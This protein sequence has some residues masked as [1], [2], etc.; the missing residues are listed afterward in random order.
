MQ[1]S[2][3]DFC[4]AD[5]VCRVRG[6]SVAMRSTSWKAVSVA[7]FDS[8]STESNKTGWRDVSLC[9]EQWRN[10]LELKAHL[11]VH[12]KSHSTPA[13]KQTN[14]LDSI[15]LST[16]EMS[17]VAKLPEARPLIGVYMCGEQE[18][19]RLAVG[20]EEETEEWITC[21]SSIACE[22]RDQMGSV[23]PHRLVAVTR[24][25]EIFFSEERPQSNSASKMHQ[26]LHHR[27]W[28]QVGGHVRMVRSGTKVRRIW[29]LVIIN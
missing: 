15:V 5:T 7:T 8:G 12:F 11:T 3:F 1:R 2:L 6:R 9:L 16:A 4:C 17:C 19:H 24:R 20:T 25:G 26:S 29:K 14:S 23:A 28:R 18:P 21:L 13:R 22:Q 27:F 10:G